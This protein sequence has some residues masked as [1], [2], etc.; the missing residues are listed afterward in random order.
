MPSN[1]KNTAIALFLKNKE[2]IQSSLKFSFMAQ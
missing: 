2:G 1:Q